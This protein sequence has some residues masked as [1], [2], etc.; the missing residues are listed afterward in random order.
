MYY[1]AKNQLSKKMF[2]IFYLA[3]EA[4]RN[5]SELNPVPT[6]LQFKLHFEFEFE[7]HFSEGAKVLEGEGEG[8]KGCHPPIQVPGHHVGSEKSTPWANTSITKIKFFN[9]KLGRNYSKSIF[10]R[11]VQFGHSVLYIFVRLV[12]N[13][14]VWFSIYSAVWIRPYA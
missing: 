3:N 4:S 13:S 6:V 14:V 11:L 8:A 9:L 12:T 1:P 10:G 2:D 7:I 5:I